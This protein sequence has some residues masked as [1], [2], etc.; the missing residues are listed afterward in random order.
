MSDF[1]VSLNKRYT[2]KHLLNLIKKPYGSRAP[3]GQFFDYP[4]GSLAVLADRLADN[5]NIRE[6]EDVIFA[7]VGDLVAEMSGEFVDALVGRIGQI[8][9]CRA[10][11]KIS[12]ES[13]ESFKKL[14][15][16]FAILIADDEGF[17]VVTDPLSFVQVYEGTDGHNDL[18]S[19][20][21]HC[22]LVASISDK[23]LHIDMVSV[24]E[25]LNFDTPI[26]PNTMYKNVR[27]LGPGR[28]YTLRS[29]AK[30]VEKQDFIYWSPPKEMRQF[31]DENELSK[32]LEGILLSVVRD[33]CDAEKVGVFLSGGLDSRLIMAAVPKTVSCIGLTFY[34]YP[35]RESRTARRVA[36]SYQR[37]WLPLIR[38]K[39]FVGN[40]IVDAVKLTGCEFECICGRWIGWVDEI[41]KL[42]LSVILGGAQFDVYLKGYFA[43]DWLCE[44][45]L[46]GLLPDRPKRK[47]Y[48]YINGISE[49][50]NKNL[51]KEI[52]DQIHFRRKHTYE[53]RADFSRGSIAEWMKL[54]PF[55]Q[56]GASFWC[57]SRRVL[58]LR[59]VA[60]D[61]RV[62]DFAFSCPIE[63]RL[64]DK[65]FMMAAKNIYGASSRI[66]I[67]N[68]GVRP[69]SGHW[70]RL[71]Q[72]AVRKLQ[73]RSV[74]VLEKL[75]REPRVQG[76]WIDYERYWQE[77]GKLADLIRGYGKNL[78]QFDGQVF[79]E[80]GLDLLKCKNINW[81]EGFRL[82]QLA[83]WKSVIEDY[84]L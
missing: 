83:V 3:E 64:G 4:W 76:S 18:V 84:K 71:A 2:G 78:E 82:L 48:D 68:D 80:R 75:G 63:L 45:H 44:K 8:K 51:T 40:T 69:D 16:A 20:G 59:L 21:T 32:E 79:E 54:S 38:D 49:F 58:P 25:F 52:V 30:K 7:W 12:L 72:R 5:R 74:G 33:R 24:G 81:R 31:G 26:F 67:A 19:I 65:I 66:P 56:D 1:L 43:S 36:K 37:D 39:E 28:L 60:M 22:D 34:N 23:S 57:A 10:N 6:R 61:R 35:N 47:A 42:D 55:S 73:D 11:G 41:S 15:G 9:N 46:R 77:S 62:L 70:G 17:N 14:N 53:E 50:W 13:D 29:R 27:E